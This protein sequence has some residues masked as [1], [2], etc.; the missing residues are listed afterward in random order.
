M[1]TLHLIVGLP[2]SG[3]TTLAELLETQHQAILLSPDEW[4]IRLFSQDLD[5]PR[6]NWR[7]D[8]I[9]D[10]LWNVAAKVLGHGIDVILDFGFWKRIEREDYRCRAKAVGA[11]TKIHYLDV[12]PSVLL[13]RLDI[14]NDLLPDGSFYIPPDMLKEWTP[15]L[16]PP[17]EEELSWS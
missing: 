7:H 1:T 3:K 16:E 6:H 5:H 9:E 8:S 17:N 12:P 14:R 4:Q 15:L 2:C 13:R 11:G 10:M